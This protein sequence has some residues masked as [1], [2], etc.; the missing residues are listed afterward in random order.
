MQQLGM[1]VRVFRKLK[2]LTQ[3]EL[4][5][6]VGLH[7]TDIARLERGRI[8]SITLPRLYQLAQA[9]G[10]QEV[11]QLLA[12]APVVS[13]LATVHPDPARLLG[14]LAALPPEAVESLTSLAESLAAISP[15]RW[16]ASSAAA[17]WHTPSTIAEVNH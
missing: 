17:P 16:T 12:E 3:R 4:G 14:A 2:Q 13:V 7:Q 11:G 9:L 8:R 6:L 10:L 1:R 5:A 15:D